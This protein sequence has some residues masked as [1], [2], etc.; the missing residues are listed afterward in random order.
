MTT[1]Y[2]LKNCQ[3]CSN[4]RKWLDVADVA[5]EF[6][7]LRTDGV[8]ATQL[9]Q[10]LAAHGADKIVN[11]RSLTWRELDADARAACAEDPVTVLQQHPTLIKRPILA[12]GSTS[13]VGFS[14]VDYEAANIRGK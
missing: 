11:K 7:D 10:W 2:G 4:A 3:S 12:Q 9:E 1:L 6:I 14:I 5:Y 8:D 13:I